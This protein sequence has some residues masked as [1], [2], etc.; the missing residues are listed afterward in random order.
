[1][2]AEEISAAKP[3]VFWKEGKREERYKNMT[4]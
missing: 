3:P 2:T 1:M 4:I